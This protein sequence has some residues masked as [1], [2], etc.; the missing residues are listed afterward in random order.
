[1]F[2]DRHRRV[3]VTGIGV[4]ASLGHDVAS[5]WAGLI[6]G[7]SGVVRISR[8]DPS[9]YA[10]QIG[11]EVRDFDPHRWMD[12]KEARRNDRFAHYAFASAKQALADAQLDTAKVDHDRFGVFFGSGIG[13]IETLEEQNKILIERGPRRVSPFL[14]PSLIPNMA[15]GIIAIDV[16]ARGP[17][18]CM[19]SAC[20]SSTH[21]IGEALKTIRAGDAD[22]MLAGGSEAPIT[23][24]GYAGFSAMKAMST[25]RNAEPARASRPFD[26][27]RD[28]FVMGEGGGMLLLETLEHARARGARIY[29]EL[30]GYG[31]SCDAYHITQPDPE[32][33]G[34]MLAMKN[35]L[36]SARLN[37]TDV[38][39]INAHGTSTQYN[40]KFETAA[41]KRVFGDHARRLKVSSTKSMTGH[42]LGGAGGLEAGVTVLGIQEQI[43][44]PTI[45]LETI[46]P[47]CSGLNFIIGQSREMKIDY[48]LS[49]SFG[50]GG[51]N[52]CLIFKRFD[53]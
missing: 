17:N 28:G 2:A 32:G 16:G 33:L 26:R 36:R 5:F 31:A 8:F 14:I 30:A 15:S 9:D 35:A 29:C 48:A 7:R 39:Y 34:L 25:S 19:V 13:G 44:P 21:A 4:V 22:V 27:G 51:T 40:D 3:V 49:N 52:G 23:P 42:L 24:I 12:P 50:F 6:A 46:D 18:F 37:P 53:G 20:A 38:G 41:I 43:A 45:N 11:A 1:M 47:D 10:C